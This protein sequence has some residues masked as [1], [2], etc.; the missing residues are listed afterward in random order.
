MEKTTKILADSKQIKALVVGATRGIGLEFCR[1]LLKDDRVERLFCTHRTSPTTELLNLQK[2]YQQRVSL[3]Q[4]DVTQEK[5]IE[6]ALQE[7]GSSVDALDLVIYC[8]GVLHDG[9]LTPEKSLRHLK[10]ENLLYSFQVNSIGAALLAKHLVPLLDRNKPGLFAGISAKVGSIGDNHLGGWY[11]YRASKAA[12]NMFLRTIALEYRHRCPSTIVVS[13]HPGT[14]DTRLSE[15]FQENVPKD[16]LSSVRETV[17]L[18][19]GVMANLEIE[20]SGKFLSWSGNE[21]P[22]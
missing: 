21:I 22:W 1:F 14:T 20:E 19:S 2:S 17:A 13:L 3:L 4:M 9:D 6:S 8:V 15:P 12:L 11:G 7:V 5:Q 10:S 18:L 16:Q